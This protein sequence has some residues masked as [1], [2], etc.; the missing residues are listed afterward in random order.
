VL[1]TSCRGS[2][3]RATLRRG[4]HLSKP[5]GRD[6]ARP[7]I[8]TETPAR[9]CPN[10]CRARMPLFRVVSKQGFRSAAVH[11]TIR[12]VSRCVLP[13]RT[14]RPDALPSGQHRGYGRDWAVCRSGPGRTGRAMVVRSGD[15]GE[16]AKRKVRSGARSTTHSI[17]ATLRSVR[18]YALF[19]RPISCL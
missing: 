13:G 4:L 9:D 2:R 10:H 17:G 18:C 1:V 3:W 7:S 11:S 15:P 16:K 8:A 14:R 5:L 19:D 12:T 6:G